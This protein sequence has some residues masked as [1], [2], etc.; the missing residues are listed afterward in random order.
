MGGS[1]REILSRKPDLELEVRAAGGRGAVQE[2]RHGEEFEI[3]ALFG[4]NRAEVS[5]YSCEVP[6]VV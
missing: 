5:K 1:G 6:G 4:P 3:A 2:R